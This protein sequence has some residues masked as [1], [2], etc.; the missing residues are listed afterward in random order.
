MFAILTL[1]MAL[2]LPVSFCQAPCQEGDVCFDA[3]CSFRDGATW[4]GAVLRGSLLVHFHPGPVHQLALSDAEL[5]KYLPST[6]RLRVIGGS[7][8]GTWSCHAGH[9]D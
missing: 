1:A 6:K 8:R 2:A 7:R 3:G 5:S 4:S 9:I